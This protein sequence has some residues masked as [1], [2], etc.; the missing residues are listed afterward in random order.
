MADDRRTPGWLARALNHELAACS[1][2]SPKRARTP[3]GRCRAGAQ[4]AR[5]G[6]AIGLCR[7]FDGAADPAGYDT[8]RRAVARGAAGPQSGPGSRPCSYMPAR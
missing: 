6:G 8:L 2:I 5:R 4:A 3:V 1:S 7:A